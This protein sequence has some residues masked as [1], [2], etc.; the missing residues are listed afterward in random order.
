MHS[1]KFK[2]RIKQTGRQIGWSSDENE[3]T[4]KVVLT[5]GAY[6]GRLMDRQRGQGSE[7]VSYMFI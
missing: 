5:E 7:K 6:E 3:Q 1:P 2:G 4:G